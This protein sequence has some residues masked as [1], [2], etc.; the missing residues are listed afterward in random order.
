MLSKIP[1]KELC[2]LQIIITN[3]VQSMARTDATR[4]DTVK[5]T[6]D[7]LEMALKEV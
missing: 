1:T 2:K 3:E 6:K 4:L 5:E 7:I